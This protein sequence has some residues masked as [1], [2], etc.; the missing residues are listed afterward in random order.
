[1]YVTKA[2]LIVTEEVQEIIMKI[3]KEQAEEDE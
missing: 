3:I 1:M 2:G